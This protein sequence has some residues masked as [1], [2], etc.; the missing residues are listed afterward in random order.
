M[1]GLARHG[2]RDAHQLAPGRAHLTLGDAL[3]D[4]A[5]LGRRRHQAAVDEVAGH[6]ALDAVTQLLLVDEHLLAGAQPP[7]QGREQLAED[8][9]GVGV[10][11]QR[12]VLPTHAQLV[13]GVEVVGRRQERDHPVEA[14]FPDPDDL[15]LAPDPAVGAG[16]APGTL[17]DRQVVLDDPREVP[18][19]DPGRPL[20]LHGAPFTPPPAS[21]PAPWGRRRAPAPP[22]PPGRAPRRPPPASPRPGPRPARPP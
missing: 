22:P 7:A 19:R 9:C 1:R 13:V 14:L 10:G 8:R 16:V 2:G 5:G 17:A 11:A 20:A 12:V 4:G 18:R 3:D 21:W 6:Y 15:L